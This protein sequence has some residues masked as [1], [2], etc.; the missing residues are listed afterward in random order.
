MKKQDSSLLPMPPFPWQESVWQ[1]FV[2]RTQTDKM[3]HA[4]LLHGEKGIGTHV[5]AKA[6]SQFTV[7]LSPLES[8]ACGKCKSCMLMSSGSFPDYMHVSLEEK[9]KQIKIDQ[10]RVV[11]DFVS[12]TSPQGG[13]KVIFIEAVELMNVNAANAL[14]KNLEEP[15]GHTLFIL[16]SEQVSRILPTIR[17]RCFQI[18]LALPSPELSLAWLKE[19]GVD[20]PEN[21]LHYANGAP[22]LAK[23]WYQTGRISE[24]T[25]IFSGM[26]QIALEQQASL[27]VAAQFSK[28]EPIAVVD[29]M[30]FVIDECL[31]HFM[32]DKP[33]SK[34]VEGLS[35]TLKGVDVTILFRLRDKLCSKKAQILISANLNPALFI[36]ELVLDWAALCDFARRSS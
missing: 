9:A 18:A 31:A 19:E 33:I 26:S 2:E 35:R 12:K 22:V 5:L 34:V 15:A 28:Y 16:T 4:I 1:K 32:A 7:C 25:S 8:I 21:L 6:M 10:I 17:S 14:L 20:D 36:E 23:E 30:Q 27:V 13:I 29:G 24:K 3:A 11:S